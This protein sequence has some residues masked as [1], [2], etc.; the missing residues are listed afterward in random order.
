MVWWGTLR[1]LRAET[2]LTVYR[3]IAIQ[4]QWLSRP[5]LGPHKMMNQRKILLSY[6]CFVRWPTRK[7]LE[8]VV[9]N[10]SNILIN[11]SNCRRDNAS[12]RSIGSLVI[13]RFRKNEN[14]RENI[15]MFFQILIFR[16][17]DVKKNY[18]GVEMHSTSPPCGK[19][20]DGDLPAWRVITRRAE[21]FLLEE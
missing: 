21:I 11:V 20:V 6:Q 10:I 9:Q 13:G 19:L 5:D 12:V 16:N 3:T 1:V 14:F 15:D 2:L 8:K 7:R 4:K 18:Y 17:R